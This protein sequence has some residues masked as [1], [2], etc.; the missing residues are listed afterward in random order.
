VI[1]HGI[2]SF[3]GKGWREWG[4]V[5]RSARRRR[6]TSAVSAL[7]GFTGTGYI[8]DD[9]VEVAP[10]RSTKDIAAWQNGKI[11]R[12]VVT[13][14]KTVYKFTLIETTKAPSS[15]PTVSPS[16]SPS[17]RARMSRTRLPLVAASRPCWMSSTGRTCAV[18]TSPSP[19]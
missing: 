6:P 2:N 10:E 18:S 14:A 8:S 19:R 3:Q 17:L 7:T 1:R 4:V 5:H 15:L 16:P 11:V 13:E 12:T 9:G